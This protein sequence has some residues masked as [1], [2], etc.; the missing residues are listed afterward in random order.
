MELLLNWPFYFINVRNT[1]RLNNAERIPFLIVTDVQAITLYP[2][3]GI[4]ILSDDWTLIDILQLSLFTQ[5][6]LDI[7]QVIFVLMD[8]GRMN[9]A[10][11]NHLEWRSFVQNW[12]LF[13][14]EEHCL[15]L[16]IRLTNRSP[17]FDLS[18]A[19]GAGHIIGGN[20]ALNW[21]TC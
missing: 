6:E 16:H 2:F 13:C 17:G 20:E 15:I 19:W 10:K 3:A 18:P 5:D 9:A 8:R 21:F 14:H 11:F 4:M 1:V 12:F 7:G